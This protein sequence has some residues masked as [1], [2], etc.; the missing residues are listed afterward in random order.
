VFLREVT[1]RL[2]QGL[3]E[4]IPDLET[5]V[6]QILTKQ[7]Y[8]VGI[9]SLTSLLA[10]RSVYCSKWA[11]GQHSIARSFD[12]DDGNIWFERLEHTWEG[13]TEWIY[14]TD[15]QG[16]QVKKFTNG[17][18]KYCGAPQLIFDRDDALETHA[19]AFI[20]ADNIKD[21]VSEL[22][23]GDMNFDV[24]I[25]NPPYQ[26]TGG[27]GGSSDSSIYHL[28][29]E[30]ALALEPR[31]LS[32]VIPSR[33][34]AGGRGLDEFR[35][36]ML[37]SQHLKEL[38]DWSDSG[39]AFPGLQIKGG[40]CYF[41]WENDYQG[42]CRVTRVSS[43][44]YHPQEPRDLGEFDVFIRDERALSIL[45]KVLPRMKKPVSELVSGD[46]PFGIATNFQEFTT[47]R[48]GSDLELHR[49]DAGKRVVSYVKR[50]LIRK[51]VSAIDRWKVFLPKAY[52]AGESYPHQ[53]LGQLIVSGPA[54]VSTQ[55]YIM[56]S[57][58]ES[59]AAANSFASYYRT[60]FFRF[61]VSLRKI[62]QDAPRGVYSWVPQQTW[63]RVWSDEILYKW[64]GITLEEVQYIESMIRPM[65]L[66][67]EGD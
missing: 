47:S 45:R 21:R 1:S 17:R 36:K 62:T 23:G 27:G 37:T 41:L 46:T 11:N 56:A 30:Q 49:I 9:T 43:G 12:S 65:D 3:E 32:M 61:F 38:V 39:E 58:F 48:T 20:H 55:T 2:V 7:V 34:M 67:V 63:D 59:E 6:D 5:R 44:E 60:R 64:Y 13:G 10:R 24:V 33:W 31:F 42:K 29:A 54:S 15:D 16:N 53:I 4:K 26:M 51:N 22:F 66:L 50:S 18:C 40:I 8:G 57:P 28:F 35:K 52:G 19:Y 25:G 14:A